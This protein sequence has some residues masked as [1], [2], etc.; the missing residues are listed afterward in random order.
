MLSWEQTEYLLKG[1]YLGLLVLVAL[2]Y[3][4][5][6]QV[7]IVGG[8]MFGTL[9][10]CMLV[11]AIRKYR[12]G[13]RPRGRPLGF[14]LFLL[15]ENPG[16]VYT[17]ILVGLCA[18]TYVTFGGALASKEMRTDLKDDWHLLYPV[19][20]GAILGLIFYYLR[21]VQDRQN[22]NWLGMLLVFAVSV[23]SIVLIRNYPELLR[24]T[25]RTMIGAV[26]L[27]GIPGFYLLTFSSMVEE[28][29]VEI[30]GLCSALGV[31]LGFLGSEISQNFGAIAVIVPMAVYFLYT[32]RILPGLRI[33]KH[34]LRGMSYAKVGRYRLALQSF[35]RAL[36]LDPNHKMAYSQLWELHRE[37]DFDKLKH[38][39]ETLSLVN[40][41]LCLE[42]ISSLLLADKPTL[43]MVHEAQGLLELVSSQRPKLQ[44]RCA[45]WRA[46]AFLHE[47]KY[48]EAQ[49][50]LE[51]VLVPQDDSLQRR[52]VLLQAWNL[53][54]ML[55]PEM[56]RRVGLP[57][58]ALPGR[59][60]EAI[61]AV[62]RQLRS[63]PDDPT[64]WELKRL[65]YPEVAEEDYDLALAS[66]PIVA[67]PSGAGGSVAAVTG[68]AGSLLQSVVGRV[69]SKVG[70][71]GMVASAVGSTIA[72]AGQAVSAAV[73]SN[74]PGR[75]MVTD[76][77]H[78]YVE[79]LG[80]ALM[81]D[82]GDWLRGT[83]FLRIAAKGN[84]TR[85]PN[86]YMQIAKAHEKHGDM[87]GLW[88]NYLN[89][90]RAG[91]AIGFANLPAED[92][93]S[94]FAVAKLLGDH[95]S[96]SDQLD[97]ALE[98]FKVYS[99][100]E[101]AGGETWRTLADL[102]ERKSTAADAAGD[103]AE[104]QQN[105]WMALHCTEHGLSYSGLANDRDLA[106]R[107]DRYLVSVTPEELKRRWE[108]IRLWFSVDYCLDKTKQILERYNGELENLDW[109]EH[110]M[111]LG[112]AAWPQS[113]QVKY[114][115]ARIRRFRGETAETL[116]LLDEVRQNKP[117]KFANNAEQ[118]A[119]YSVH[120]LLGE[121]YIDEKP[122][123]AVLCLQEFRNSDKAGADSMYSLGRAY[124]N[125]GDLTRAARCY[126]NVTAYEGH[127]RF[128]DARD[129]LERVKKR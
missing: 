125:L 83:M 78:N 119:W 69:A 15:L 95:A 18:G 58:L 13:Y 115:R 49:R 73:A 85:G 118:E 120:R 88:D 27:L 123:Q 68:A 35:N 79:Q 108:N 19:L 126:E 8:I 48:E 23:G 66:A 1:L 9:A 2:L 39:P 20:G 7:A 10:L 64:A 76:F 40:Y 105:L 127:P 17:G 47:K 116:A 71:G 50:E 56:K 25:Q 29:E 5:W 26:L 122:D 30:A 52:A 129:G 43:A 53:A 111:A 24:P 61:A 28:S 104:Y 121:M 59:R 60:L 62:E 34:A 106:E 31:G 65:L 91:K 6:L 101:K 67:V 94:L 107:K 103:A 89:A 112:H 45:Y 54:L 4:T 114:Q 113:I 42:R 117:E 86:L 124:E 99:Q 44:P 37:M 3:P 41:E 32:R 21:G 93:V 16:L 81:E 75:R 100:Y 36:V 77:D 90:L 97:V 22:R 11:A 74:A 33:F 57:Q 38:D 14:I 128:Y 110:L 51:S 96:K 63:K 98:A 84:P 92:K 80:L 109:A 12:E 70:L 55:H 46:V 87:P 102:F 82:S 72:A